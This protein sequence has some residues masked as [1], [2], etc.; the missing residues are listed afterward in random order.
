MDVNVIKVLSDNPVLT[1]FLVIGLGYLVGNI[2]FGSIEVGSTIGVL[3]AGMLFGHYG[4]QSPAMAMSAGF[5]LFIFSVGLQ[6]GPT[7]FSAFLADGRRYIAL[8]FIVAATAFLSAWLLSNLVQLDFGMNAGL[9]AGAL[10]STPTLAGAQDAVKSGLAV[11]PEG[12]TSEQAQQNISV[13]Y[14][15]TYIIGTVAVILVIRYVPILFKINLPAAAWQLAR[16][17][18]MIGRK[19]QK[20]RTAENLPIIR[21]YEVSPTAVGKTV[22]QRYLELGKVGRALKVR[23]GQ[24]ILEAANDLVFK[25]GDVVSIVSSL[26]E[27][28]QAQERLGSEVLDP[29][30]LNYQVI[31]REIIVIDPKAIGRPLQDLAMIAKYGCFATG[32]RRAAIN[33]P[34]DANTVLQKGD[35]LEVT[36]EEAHLDQL[37]EAIGYVEE[38]VEKTDLVTFA[39][40]IVAGTLLGLVMI[41]FGDVS[42]GL[43][44]AGGLLTVGIILGFVSSINPTFGRVPAAA[45]YILMELGLMI[46]M[47]G[48]GMG[49]GAGVVDAFLSA[50]PLMI[51]CSLVVT[52]VPLLIAFVI[53]LYVMKMNPALL[54][55]ALTGAMT[56]TPSLNIVTSAA[57]S[58]IPALGY[59]GTYTF[60][61][62]LLT[63]AGAMIVSL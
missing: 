21:A 35:R 56:S 2:K 6:A 52:I 58:E 41:K 7:F 3:L 44:S 20:K 48:V 4:F 55:G 45:R 32:L 16:D 25:E 49:A 34:V 50:G 42:I 46:F 14:A 8:A 62:V 1:L 60:A 53:G 9:L 17:R 15:I 10:T 28:Q 39:F 47:A 43:G 12:M 18:G 37:A 24:E 23:R 38:Q 31:S 19:S 59:A 40:G 26:K 61:N 27:H 54:L 63:F 36:G 11:L 22:E 30:L 57:K 13:V 29:Q 5:T 33:L 51:L